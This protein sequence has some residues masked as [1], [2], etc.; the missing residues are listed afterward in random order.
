MVSHLG[1][2][3]VREV[4]QGWSVETEGA[5]LLFSDRQDV[6]AQVALNLA[7]RLLKQGQRYRVLFTPRDI[8]APSWSSSE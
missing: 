6:A 4:R 8:A 5:V 2:I 1:T 7:S 3:A